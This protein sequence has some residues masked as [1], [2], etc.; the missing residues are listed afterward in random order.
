MKKSTKWSAPEDCEQKYIRE[1]GRRI[2]TSIKKHQRL[3][4]KVDTERSEIAEHIALTGH[5]IDWNSTER[6]AIYGE[7]SRKRNIR[8]AVDILLQVNPMKRR[9]EEGRVSDNLVYCL[10]RLGD[11]MNPSKRRRLEPGQLFNN[12]KRHHQ[13]AAHKEQRE[14]KKMLL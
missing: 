7:N 9:L 3:C 6:L 8:E 2:N 10:R 13:G 1:T 14:I 5:T 4:R 12:R 11:S